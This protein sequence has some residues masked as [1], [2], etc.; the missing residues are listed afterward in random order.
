MAFDFDRPVDGEP[1]AMVGFSGNRLDRQSE[2]RGEQSLQE[3][4]ANDDAVAYGFIGG[5]VLLAIDDDAPRARFPNAHLQQLGLK[6]GRTILLGYDGEMPVLA[7]ALAIDG[8]KIAAPYETAGLRQLMIEGRIGDD[9]LAEIAQ[10]S[11]LL[12]WNATNRYC[13]RCGAQSEVRIGGY[14]RDCTRCEAQIFPRTDPV[15]IMLAVDGDN[16]L[17]G[18]S[19][20]FPTGFYSCL[21]GFV[22][23][24][25]TI[26]EAV[27]RETLEESGVEIARVRYFASQPWPFPHSL[28]IG[29][30]G[31]AVSRAITIDGHELEDCRWFARSEIALMIE[32]QHPEGILMPPRGSIAHHI[33]RAWAL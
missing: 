3:A 9:R 27:R 24:G 2:N 23:P 6:P 26:E 30:V 18:R 28:M 29:C 1:S 22:E 17:L 11:S 16:C 12:Y 5:E 13:A 7:H 32:K 8:D 25:E 21:A 33:I 31:E 20:H 19:H 14:R 15:V 10:A 4:M